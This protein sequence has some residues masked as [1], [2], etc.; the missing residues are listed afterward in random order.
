MGEAIFSLY[1]RS[2][3]AKVCSGF[4]TAGSYVLPV[5]CEEAAKPQTELSP[6]E[7]M[8]IKPNYQGIFDA[9]RTAKG[10]KR[11]RDKET[12]SYSIDLISGPRYVSD[13]KSYRIKFV[14]AT[15]LDAGKKGAV[16]HDFLGVQMVYEK[17]TEKR[18]FWINYFFKDKHTLVGTLMKG[19]DGKDADAQFGHLKEEV[20]PL[21][22]IELEG[23]AKKQKKPPK[24]DR[25]FKADPS[26]FAGNVPSFQRIG[27]RIPRRVQHRFS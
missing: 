24:R 20:L 5:V 27:S 26:S 15:F 8:E 11:V 9:L 14:E 19:G 18:A 13:D 21:L 12:D 4:L 2:V 6:L 25:R 23:R 10:V 3:G 16:D 17:G 22:R 7:K 1:S